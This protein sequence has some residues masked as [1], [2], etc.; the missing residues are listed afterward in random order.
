MPRH[1]VEHLKLRERLVHDLRETK[2]YAHVCGDT[3]S[4]VADQALI[5][6][7]RATDALKLAKKNLHQI[8]GAYLDPA[9]A[10]R[11]GA[12]LARFPHDPS[13]E[14]VKELCL[15]L[16]RCHASSAERIPF[17]EEL[18]REVFR[19]VPNP[20]SV[21][22]VGCGLH[23]CAVPWMPLGPACRYE[24]MDVDQ[25]LIDLLRELFS[26]LPGSHRADVRDMIVSVPEIRAD[27]V[28]L[29]KLLPSLE[30]IDRGS[31]LVLLRRVRARCL[32]VSFPAKSLGGR[33]KG[34]RSHYAALW[35]PQF[36]Q[37]GYAIVTLAFPNETVY[38]L[39]PRNLAG[40]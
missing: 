17:M 27:V 28:F 8:C 19:R 36:A 12:V 7:R 35:L 38:L 29:L 1:R 30:Q 5:R 15:E 32:V 23:P 24:A 2:K 16:L 21:V 39:T 6:R 18:Y 22:D 40:C 3:L 31:A 9:S 13:H 34:M 20:G 25:R 26:H 4:R 14:A 10:R 37:L 33:E 11:A